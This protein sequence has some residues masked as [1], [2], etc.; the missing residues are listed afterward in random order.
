VQVVVDDARPT[1]VLTM[2]TVP[3]GVICHLVAVLTTL[4]AETLMAIVTK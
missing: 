4:S 2:S 3:A 1:V